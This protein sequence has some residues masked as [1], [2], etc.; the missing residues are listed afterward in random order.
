MGSMYYTI[1]PGALITSNAT[2]NTANDCF[3]VKAG[4]T[5]A[6]ALKWI[7]MIGRSGGLTALS[8]I[9]ARLV[10]WFT[11]ASSAG[12]A[13]TPYPNDFGMQASKAT[14][15][16]SATTL[17]SGTGGP[18]NIAAVGCSATG[19]GQMVAPQATNDD[20]WLLEGGATMSLDLENISATA[21]L[22]FE[23]TAGVME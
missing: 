9:A 3:F 21:S 11:T 1:S 14:A 2:P 4:A 17:T 15:A 8:S 13:L 10:K 20:S 5:R 23:V 22:P 18:S 12:T 16:Y 19:P 7:Q 6:V